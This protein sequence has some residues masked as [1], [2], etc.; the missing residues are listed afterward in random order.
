MNPLLPPAELTP[1][2]QH[3]KSSAFTCCEESLGTEKARPL[4]RRLPPY[5]SVQL[6][7]P[8]DSLTVLFILFSGLDF[9]ESLKLKKFWVGD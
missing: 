6:W 7:H 5:S 2:S 3:Y 8:P 4:V 1:A 9:K